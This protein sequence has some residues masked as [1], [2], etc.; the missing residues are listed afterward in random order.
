M[1]RTT[2]RIWT[3]ALVALVSSAQEKKTL[4]SA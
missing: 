3:L 2:T 4:R 1:R